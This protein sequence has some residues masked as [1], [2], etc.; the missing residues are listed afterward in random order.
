MQSSLAEEEEEGEE[1]EE[2]NKQKVKVRICWSS[3]NYLSN[4]LVYLPV[5]TTT[6][7][8]L[9]SAQDGSIRSVLFHCNSLHKV[10]W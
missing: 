3:L 2:E 7:D 4:W 9:P 5:E 10:K 6:I 1:A 8:M